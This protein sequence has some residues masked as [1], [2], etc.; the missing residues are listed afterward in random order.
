MMLVKRITPL[1]IVMFV[2]SLVSFWIADYAD[3]RS[4]SGGRSFSSSRS[5]KPPAQSRTAPSSTNRSG[6][7]TRGLAGGFMGGALGSMLFGGMG[8]GLGGSGIGLFPILLIAGVGYFVYRRFS[9]RTS[10]AGQYSNMTGAD[11]S[12]VVPG[13]PPMGAADKV[14]E[15]IALIRR[16]EADFDPNYFKEVAQDVFFQVQA[17]WMRRDIGS[18]RHLLGEQLAREYEETFSEMRQKGRIN[19]LENIAVRNVDVVDAGAENNE[20]FIVILFTANLLDY[21][22]DEQSGDLISGSN[23]DPV[24]FAEKW[25][26][27]RPIGTQDWK[28]EGLEVVDG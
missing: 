20:E 27:A 2:F 24:K 4:R 3:A 7:F 23:T 9:N 25:T 19:K 12:F 21:T 18:Y 11:R 13:N 22:M 5:Y 6:S 1:L 28:L 10:T 14:S 17:G 15:G 16:S 26:W 8:G